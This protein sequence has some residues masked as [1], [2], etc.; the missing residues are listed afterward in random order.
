MLFRSLPTRMNSGQFTRACITFLCTHLLLSQV[1]ATVHH[2]DLFPSDE[3]VFDSKILDP[4]TV[5]GSPYGGFARATRSRLA[6]LPLVLPADNIAGDD[7]DTE[8]TT[9][10]DSLGRRYVCRT[11]HQDEVTVASFKGSVFDQVELQVKSDTQEESSS[12]DKKEKRDKPIIETGGV[13]KPKV[14]GSP[15]AS[16]M[17]ALNGVC[18]QMHL[19][20]WSYEWCYQTY[21]RQFHVE[22]TGNDKVKMQDVTI[23]GKMNTRRVFTKEQWN[24]L[25]RQRD[26]DKSKSSTSRS[27]LEEIRREEE[28]EKFMQ[29]F[30]LT[31]VGMGVVKEEYKNGDK[32]DATKKPRTSTVEYRCCSPEK[33]K[34]LKPFIIHHGKPSLSDIAAI[35]KVDEPKTCHYDILICTPLLCEGQ[36]DNYFIGGKLKS[37]A[38]ISN[39]KEKKGIA[40]ANRKPKKDNE[41]IRDTIERTL[42]G[43]CLASNTNEWWAYEFCHGVHI[44][45]YHEGNVFDPDTGITT[46][47]VESEYFLGYYDADNLESF[48]DAVE[49]KYVVNVTKSLFDSSTTKKSP[50]SQRG[51][52]AYFYQEYTNGQICDGSDPDV[53]SKGGIPRSTTI[54]FFCGSKY[55]LSNVNED[56]TCHY[57][58]DVT[59]PDLC[60]H[61]FFR[62]PD[63]KK[64]VIKCL[65]IDDQ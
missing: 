35:V 12:E 14:T 45:Q 22:F 1:L 7:N 61:A 46:R 40:P 24:Q 41:S 27:R 4:N 3:E 44:R 9:V 47:Q 49:I 53:K 48:E 51:S 56:S 32:C 60:G 13:F 58:V 25:Q 39:G 34:T 33:L 18:T 38:T 57:V 50:S 36:A 19:G 8:Y 63:N 16:V 54:R 31:E 65:P 52:G 20:W 26:R 21:V 6:A 2:T 15:L 30:L 10:T 64:R 5:Y 37:D 28:I 42:E 11:Y 43:I 23:L 29:P 17:E 55:E 59:I 62:A